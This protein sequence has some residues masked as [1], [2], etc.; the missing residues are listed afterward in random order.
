MEDSSKGAEAPQAV[1]SAAF[2]AAD[3][4][5]IINVINSY[6]YFLDEFGAER[7]DALFID[8]PTLEIWSGGKKLVA[9]LPQF[10]NLVQ[11]RHENFKRENIQ[12]RHILSAPRF[13]RQDGG[14]AS[15]QV[16]LQYYE[17]QA[18]GRPVLATVG[19]YEFTAVR[20][21]GQWKL[22]RWIARPDSISG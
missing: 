1:G 21:G 4:L 12:R 6:G 7:L 14:A 8:T 18:G 16:Y 19:V 20:Q 17:T 22:D 11:G 3:R 10:R 5:A 9:G 13:E 2:D 15:G